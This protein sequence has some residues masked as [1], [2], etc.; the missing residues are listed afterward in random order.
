M[1]QQSNHGS[2]LVSLVAAGAAALI[3]LISFGVYHTLW[4]A[5]VPEVYLEGLLSFVP[6]SFALAWA[7]TA[8]RRADASWAVYGMVFCGASCSGSPWCPRDQL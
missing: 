3:G 7:L 8:A 1:T 2:F 4:I 6:A 5:N